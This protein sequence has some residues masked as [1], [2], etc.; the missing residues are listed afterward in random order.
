MG[1]RIILHKF[2]KLKDMIEFLRH[3]TGMCGEPHPS[4]LTLL[5]GTPVVGYVMYK[6]KRYGKEK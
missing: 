6:I 3:A 5:M 2:C 4:L 1:Q